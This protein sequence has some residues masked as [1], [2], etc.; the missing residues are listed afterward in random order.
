MGSQRQEGVSH[1]GSCEPLHSSPSRLSVCP[2]SV[3]VPVVQDHPLAGTLQPTRG[4]AKGW[5]SP[6]AVSQSGG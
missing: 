4:Q 6:V 1:T 5:E 2:A 3:L